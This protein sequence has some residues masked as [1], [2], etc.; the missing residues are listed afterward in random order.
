M[1]IVSPATERAAVT[2]PA[3]RRRHP[4][5]Q[6]A[7]VAVEPW[8]EDST[9]ADLDEARRRLAVEEARPPAGGTFSGERREFLARLRRDVDELE[10]LA[11]DRG[12]GEVC[13]SCDG[14]GFDEGPSGFVDGMWFEAVACG[15]CGGSGR[16]PAGE[17]A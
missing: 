16:M 13:P 2:D 1:S 8:A 12:L 6:Q 5:R 17:V 4:N 3:P 9:L 11:A 10:R 14:T 7:A 15:T